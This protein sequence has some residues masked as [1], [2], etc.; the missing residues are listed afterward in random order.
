MGEDDRHGKDDPDRSA[1]LA[2]R[3]RFIAVALS[4]LTTALTG[5]DD[6]DGTTGPEPCL[7]TLP[8][9]TG[10]PEPC[11]EVAPADE[12]GDG[13]AG[14]D[15]GDG[16]GDDGAKPEPCLKVAP[17]EPCLSPVVPPEPDPKPEACLKVAPPQPC[18]DVAPEP[19]PKPKPKPQPC[20]KVKKP[21]K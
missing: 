12:G 3:N 13:D 18:L 1:I 2:R 4:G 7:K 9:S 21:E 20:L 16:G 15:A 17:P 8:P 19:E 14:E 11:L 10:T 6:K 5:C